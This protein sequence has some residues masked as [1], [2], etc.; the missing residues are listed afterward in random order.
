MSVFSFRNASTRIDETLVPHANFVSIY[1]QVT[2]YLLYLTYLRRKA[3]ARES[4]LTLALLLCEQLVEPNF[5]YWLLT[6]TLLR[7]CTNAAVRALH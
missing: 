3:P 4:S 1:N 2:L 7:C 6:M 5:K